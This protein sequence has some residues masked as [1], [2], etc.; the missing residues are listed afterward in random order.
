MTVMMWLSKSGTGVRREM[1][2]L[3]LPISLATKM[4]KPSTTVYSNIHKLWGPFQIDLF[5][6][7]LKFKVSTCFMETIS[8]CLVYWCFTKLGSLLF[9]CLPPFSLIALCL[10]K[11]EEDYSS[12][13]LLV[14][15]WPTQPWSPVLLRSLVD[16]PR[17]LPNSKNLLTQPQ[18]QA[19]H[20]LGKKFKLFACL[21]SGKEKHFR[22]R[23]LYYHA[24]MVRQHP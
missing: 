17:I 15:L 13:M 24:V 12:G 2:G 16:H 14:P 18:S 1:W 23:Y 8:G 19:S 22:R 10:Q 5:P 7:R 4:L 20:P 6:S 9:L 11:M 3:V 21:V